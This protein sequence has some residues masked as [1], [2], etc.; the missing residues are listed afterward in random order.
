[1]PSVLSLDRKDDAYEYIGGI[2]GNS[3]NSQLDRSN[4]ESEK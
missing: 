3:G 4:S 2:Y 1:M